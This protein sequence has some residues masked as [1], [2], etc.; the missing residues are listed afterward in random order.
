MSCPI[1][2]KFPWKYSEN[3]LGEH[4][5]QLG[6]TFYKW[7]LSNTTEKT[8]VV[9]V[10]TRVY[11]EAPFRDNQSEYS[12]DPGVPSKGKMAEVH[13]GP[14]T[15][16]SW[17]LSRLHNEVVSDLISQRITLSLTSFL[18]PLGL[19]EYACTSHTGVCGC[20]HPFRPVNLSSK[21]RDL[22]SIKSWR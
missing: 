19:A 2:N 15:G 6:H 11:V 3:E 12:P 22:F 4:Y 5:T 7:T 21:E 14:V 10:G 20:F 16:N 17:T 8:D 9:H 1:N 18:N 13:H